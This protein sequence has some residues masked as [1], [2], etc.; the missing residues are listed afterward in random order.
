MH[1]S[2][3]HCGKSRKDGEA[4]HQQCSLRGSLS[5][6][7]WKGAALTQHINT[8]RPD[9]FGR[10]R[11]K[12]LGITLAGASWLGLTF[13]NWVRVGVGAGTPLNPRSGSVGRRTSPTL[14][15]TIPNRASDPKI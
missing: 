10:C 8:V 6:P 12:L 5:P 1:V 9:R 15:P 4:P 13:L 7:C 14:G 11:A 3:G 2:R